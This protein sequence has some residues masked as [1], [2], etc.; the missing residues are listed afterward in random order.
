MTTRQTCVAT[1]RKPLVL[2]LSHGLKNPELVSLIYGEN[3]IGFY[4]RF[5]TRTTYAELDER[6]TDFLNDFAEEDEA[7]SKAESDARWAEEC[8]KI[9]RLVLSGSVYSP[10]DITHIVIRR[11]EYERQTAPNSSVFGMIMEG[12]ETLTGKEPTLI[13][14][15]GG[16]HSF[17]N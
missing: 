4:R 12:F 10:E 3:R 16:Y 9:V 14:L 17:L 7:G 6:Y 1:T 8:A 5:T 15:E 11:D 2:F 13:A